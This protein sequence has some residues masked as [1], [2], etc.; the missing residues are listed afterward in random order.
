MN[1]KQRDNDYKRDETKAKSVLT[2]DSASG[3]VSEEKKQALLELLFEYSADEDQSEQQAHFKNAL[4]IL[5][6]LADTPDVSDFYEEVGR[7]VG[8]GDGIVLVS[9]L[10][11]CMLNEML[12]FEN[13]ETG[14]ALNLNR[15]NIGVV[16]LGEYTH[17]EAGDT[18]RRSGKLLQ[19][20]VGEALLGR[21][22]NPLALPLDGKGEILTD[23]ARPIEF[24]APDVMA[25]QSVKRPLQTGVT[26]V[27]ALIPIGRGQ[28]EL[29]IGDRKTG[30]TTLAL[31]TIINQRGQNVIC[32]YVAIGQKESSVKEAI[33]ILEEHGAMDY[34]TV[35]MASAGDSTA[36]QYLAPYAGCAM[37]EYFMYRGQDV[38]IVYDDLTKHAVAYRELSLLLKRP[39]GR[40]AYP[41]DVFYLHSRL[42][43]RAACLSEASGGGSLTAL[44]II[45]TQYGDVSA[46]IPTNV[47]SITDGQIFL[48]ADLFKDGQRPAVSVGVSV[49][50]VGGAAQVKAMKAVA[51]SLRLNLAQYR[52]LSE[53]TKFG[54]DFDKETTKRLKSGK[55]FMELLI[56][57]QHQLFS[58]G[59]Q[60]I[61][62]FAGQQG[63][64]DDI[65]A[66]EI[67]IWRR[68]I[69]E[70]FNEHYAELLERL[71]EGE[72][73]TGETEEQALK[74]LNC[75][76]K[77]LE[78]LP[79]PDAVSRLES[80]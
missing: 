28:R 49:S 67:L 24:P 26:A 32:V 41:G 46:Y 69:A 5:S 11:D 19:V 76:F 51:G 23:E 74:G 79:Y 73:L 77:P 72:K 45:E 2:K 44:P 70:V 37:A 12:L 17:I 43:E 35:V 60:I 63:F 40:E 29:I 7:V 27:D 50:R 71:A 21:V 10:H 20:P 64:F 66:E 53:F 4:R 15:H 62:L 47:I 75:V 1:D 3:A 14:L 13:G 8:L 52:E 30:K 38:L 56:Q 68:K 33:G 55:V 25:R 36:L 34:T 22:V 9:G 54:S 65:P 61:F 6:E 78:M 58:V 48:D 31:D 80:S 57:K 59:E 39:P 42:L 18:V 16:I